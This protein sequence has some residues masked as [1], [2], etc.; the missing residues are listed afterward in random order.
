MCTSGVWVSILLFGVSLN[1]FSIKVILR[2]T[3]KQMVNLCFLFNLYTFIYFLTV[4]VCSYAYM[5]MLQCR[6]GS[7]FVDL[8]L[9]CLSSSSIVVKRQD[10]QANFLIKHLMGSWQ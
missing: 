10:N 7:H 9:S 2:N 3:K 4:H 5:K 1:I 8:V 6:H